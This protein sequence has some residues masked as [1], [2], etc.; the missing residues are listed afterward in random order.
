M[1]CYIRFLF[2]F[3][4]GLASL[5]AQVVLNHGVN[6][7]VTASCLSLDEAEILTVATDNNIRVWNLETGELKKVI[8]LQYRVL[9]VYA[10]N[11]K[12]QFLVIFARKRPEVFDI[13]NGMFV[14]VMNPS[15]IMQGVNNRIAINTPGGRAIMYD[16]A[17]RFICAFHYDELRNVHETWSGI[18]SPVSV[19][20]FSPFGFDG[21]Y[22]LKI[23]MPD[24]IVVDDQIIPKPVVHVSATVNGRYVVIRLL[25][26]TNV[27]LIDCLSNQCRCIE[28]GRNM[29]LDRVLFTNDMNHCVFMSMQSSLVEVFSLG[30]LT[31]MTLEDVFSRLNV[32]VESDHRVV[33]FAVPRKRRRFRGSDDSE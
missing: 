13:Q 17:E 22:V 27:M 15:D 6:N 30:E 25:D 32:G 26:H 8:A 11:I 10:T 1:N 31:E 18:D 2:L 23:E 28:R 7:K 4:F 21:N 16:A 9:T 24:N 33:T 14:E 3:V 5:N 12:D 19:S 20:R 29:I